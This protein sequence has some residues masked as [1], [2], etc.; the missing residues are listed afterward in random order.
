MTLTSRSWVQITS[1]FD[2]F[3]RLARQR[4]REIL[5]NNSDICLLWMGT[6]I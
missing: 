5:D 4:K 1:S 3:A 6:F 2:N